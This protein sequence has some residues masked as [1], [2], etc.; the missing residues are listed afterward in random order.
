[1]AEPLPGMERTALR[2]NCSRAMCLLRGFYRIC[3]PIYVLSELMYYLSFPTS[4]GRVLTDHLYTAT[5]G[6]HHLAAVRVLLPGWRRE[7]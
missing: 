6:K 3:A 7:L 2:A 1:M 4:A 5:K